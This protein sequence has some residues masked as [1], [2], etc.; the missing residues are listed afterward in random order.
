MGPWKRINGGGPPSKAERERDLDRE[1]QNH[2]DL[3]AEED[4][5]PRARRTFGNTT[6]VKEDVRA[7]WRGSRIEQLARDARFALRQIRR[8]PRFSA[9]AIATLALGIGGMAAMF[10]AFDTVLLRPLPYADADRLVMVWD[11]LSHEGIP[12]HFPAPAEW[13]EW[14]RRNTVFGDMAATRPEDATLSGDAEPE[15]VPARRTSAN[16]W[17]VLGVAPEIGRVF[18]QDE[19]D[20]SVRVAVISHGLWQRRYGG[21]RDALGQTITVNDNPYEIIGIMPRDFFFLPGRDVDIWMPLSLPPWMRNAF[22]WHDAQIVGRLKPEVTVEQARDAMAALSLEMT[23]KDSRGPHAV[24]VTPLREELAGKTHT[25]VVLLLCASAALLAIGCVNLA[26]LLMSRGAARGREVAVRAALGAGRGRLIA[27][28]LTESVVLAGIGAAAGLAL[29]IPAMQLLE[30]LVPETMG[31]V[32]LALDWRVVAFSA[33]VTMAATL[34][35]GLLPALRGARLAPERGLRE[36]SRGAA[37][38]SSHSFQ[39]AL[40]VIQ[41]TLAVVLLASG[42]LLLQA[43]QSLQHADL[44]LQKDRLLTF[45]TP[46]FRYRDFDTRLAF[47]NEQLE[48]IRAIP[49]VVNAGATSRLPLTV[50]DSAA[51][52]YWLDGQSKDRVAGQVALMRVVTHDYLPTIGARLREGRLF[53]GS[54][55]RSSAPVAIVNESFANR[56]FP[57]R[58]AIGARFKHGNLGD[59]GYWYTIVGVV[60][61]IREVGMAEDLRPAVYRLHEHADQVGASPNGI[62]VRTSVEPATIVAAVRQAI[63][64][65]DRNMPVAHVRTV[66]DI[67]DSQLSPAT[68]GAALLSAFAVLALLLASLGLYGVLS[69]AV[70]QRQKEIGVR[71]ALGATPGDILFSIGRR[72]L[73]LTLIGLAL[74]LAL[75]P[76]AARLMAALLYGVQPRYAMSAAGVSL[77]LLIV[78]ALACL[79]PALRAARVDPVGALRAE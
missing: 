34:T 35:F 73:T 12:R 7:E 67:V 77:I 44:G 23:A 51:T 74:G 20:K 11:D 22:S 5:S 3:E 39:N 37:G 46:L 33:V 26:N 21:S 36:G 2:L 8:N 72:G 49:G 45:E 31:P 78:A 60:K 57:G 38:A 15:Q 63:W 29:A 9:M 27:Q 50:M 10:S 58:S 16:F 32:R 13:L 40:I 65:I 30:A 70:A 42:G 43:F 52:F 14:Q 66:E 69:Y 56:N 79:V 24:V 1:I 18:N 55:R 41:T 48:R 53:D 47:V 59:K 71:M 75:T 25:T 4:G 17:A 6:L 19:D 28:F 54:D 64:S 61:E 68:Q 62:V 76:V